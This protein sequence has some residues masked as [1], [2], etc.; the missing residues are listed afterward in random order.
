MT[1][2]AWRPGAEAGRLGPAERQVKMAHECVLFDA[3]ARLPT[4]SLL[5]IDPPPARQRPTLFLV[6]VQVPRV[7]LRTFWCVFRCRGVWNG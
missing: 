3:I 7:R 2:A 1:L 6:F 4:G 5:A